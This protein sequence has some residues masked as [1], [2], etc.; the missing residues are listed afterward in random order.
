MSDPASQKNSPYIVLALLSVLV[1]A[2]LVVASMYFVGPNIKTYSEDTIT[3]DVK[4]AEVQ[5]VIAT[6]TS[7]PKK[8]MTK[9]ISTEISKKEP[10]LQAEKTKPE[11][12]GQNKHDGKA[13]KNLKAERT[14]EVKAEVK[15]DCNIQFTG[16]QLLVKNTKQ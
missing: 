10:E 2:T 9:A 12:V 5:A 13:E 6:Q 16:N 8:K 4:T 14:V 1:V 11:E 15:D 7:E 3:K